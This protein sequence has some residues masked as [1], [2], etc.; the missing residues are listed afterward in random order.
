MNNII[1]ILGEKK[2]NGSIQEPLRIPLYL[3]ENKKDY[4]ENNLLVRHNPDAVF[5]SDLELIENAAEE[6]YVSEFDSLIIMEAC[7]DIEDGKTCQVLYTDLDLTVKAE[8]R[9]NDGKQD[10]IWRFYFPSGKLW[11]TLMFDNGT[12]NGKAFL[13]FDDDEGNIKAQCE[14]E[15]GK[16]LGTYRE[17]YKNGERKAQM[18]YDEGKLEGEAQFFYESGTLKIEGEYKD[19]EKVGKWKHYTET[20]DL[21]DKEKIKRDRKKKKRD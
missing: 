15:D 16:I 11:G 10:G 4:F 14:F 9:M 8:G 1:E 21:M 17:F 5:D 13:Y 18:E 6:T 20:G 7:E 3:E 12:V 19:G 2:F